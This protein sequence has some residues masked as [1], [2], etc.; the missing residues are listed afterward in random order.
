MAL[1]E[2][3]V[4]RISMLMIKYYEQALTADEELELKNTLSS[5]LA[6]KKV[7]DDLAKTGY[8][9]T[10]LNSMNRFDA[11]ATLA[12]FHK[13]H[14]PKK[15]K[16][17]IFRLSTLIAAASIILVL[18][19][20]LLYFNKLARPKGDLASN[21]IAP[22][23]NTATLVLA[24]GKRIT[25]DNAK[26]GELVTEAGV[27][28][29]KTKEGQ[30]VYTID[31]NT[32][33]DNATQDDQRSQRSQQYNT[34][35]TANG[36]TFEVRLPDGSKVWLNAGTSLK[37]PVSFN[38]QAQRKVELSGEAYFE[39]FKDKQHPFI[40]Q[41]E[42]QQVEVLGTR[43]NVNTY[44]NEPA[45]KTTL[46]EGSVKVNE[47][48]ILKPNQQSVLTAGQI[49]VIPVLAESYIDWQEGVF[50]FEYET[51]PSVM[52]K[53]ARWYNVEIIYVDTERDNQTFSGYVSRSSNVSKVLQTLTEISNLEFKLKGK[54]IVVSKTPK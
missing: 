47:Q 8:V 29:T 35:I 25:L 51:L 37:Y 34:L 20:G 10:E 3:D 40:V 4:S 1:H 18:S 5:D 7:F 33:T 44:K 27:T 53:I 16:P 26:N 13:K 23:K 39:V 17:F 19:I 14:F 46:L 36:E 6:A 11:T 12:S 9:K 15:E 50:N 2:K 32:N 22:G 43:F 41:S 38:A 52:R 45:I 21:D 49:K 42:G 28:I 54:T 24:N 31:D 30:I 48:T